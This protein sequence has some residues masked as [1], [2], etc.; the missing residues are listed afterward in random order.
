MSNDVQTARTR[1]A[2]GSATPRRNVPWAGDLCATLHGL[3]RPGLH[4]D[5]SEKKLPQAKKT[6]P[7]RPGTFVKGE[8]VIW[9]TKNHLVP[10][11]LDRWWGVGVFVVLIRLAGDPGARQPSQ[12]DEG[13]HAL[14]SHAP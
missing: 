1:T 2:R 8:R 13:N 9:G 6:D 7:S 5:Q 4:S 12:R 3:V 10:R 11:G 14:A